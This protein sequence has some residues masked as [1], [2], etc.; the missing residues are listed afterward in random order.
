MNAKQVKQVEDICNDVSRQNQTVYAMDAPLAQAKAIQGL[1]AV[2]DEVTVELLYCD[3]AWFISWYL[4]G[5]HRMIVGI[6]CT[7]HAKMFLT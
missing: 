1:R 2:F 5:V 7:C 6:V 4:S 3:C